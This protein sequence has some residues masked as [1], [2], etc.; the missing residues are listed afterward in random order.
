MI[1]NEVGESGDVS[2]RLTRLI[3]K[4]SRV[5]GSRASP[6]AAWRLLGIG[7]LTTVQAIFRKSTRPNS[8]MQNFTRDVTVVVSFSKAKIEVR[9]TE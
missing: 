8:F 4:A 9:L 2:S 5:S 6:L 7:V 1:D 3:G